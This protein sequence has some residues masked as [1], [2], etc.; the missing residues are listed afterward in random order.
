MR[1]AIVHGEHA[2]LVV[3]DEDRAAPAAHHPPPLR[4][5]LFDRPDA[6]EIVLSITH[7]KVPCA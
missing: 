3:D 1:A 4:L 6:D 2:A 5:Q 7:H